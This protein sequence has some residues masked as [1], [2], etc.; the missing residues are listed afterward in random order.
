MTETTT[1]ASLPWLERR[2]AVFL[3][4][5]GGGENR[6]NGRWLDAV[7]VALDE[8]Q[9]AD[10]PRALVTKASGKF[11]SNGLDLDWLSANTEAIPGFSVGMRQ[12][13]A[14][15]LSAPFPTVAAVQGHAFAAGAVL[16]LAHDHLVMREDR[17]Y[18]C[19][20]EVDL[21]IPFPEGVTELVAARMETRVAHDATLSGRRYTGP[22]ALT[23]HI[24][25]AV[26]ALDDVLPMAL[27]YANARA[28]S[29][30]Q[31]L[32]TIK[33]RLYAPTL[34]ALTAA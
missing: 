5:L 32:Q 17:G 27:A 33:Q 12:L 22:Q 7:N 24:V 6:L 11:W 14:R 1:P 10:R 29:N 20:P 21:G 4:D 15:L 34:Q 23:A 16:A 26:A 2:D 25:D 3:L 8:V 30:P 9:A 28:E 19:L 31:T 13:Y 18:F